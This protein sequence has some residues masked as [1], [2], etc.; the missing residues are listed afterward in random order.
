VIAWDKGLGLDPV[1]VYMFAA[2]IAFFSLVAVEFY[3]R[4]YRGRIEDKRESIWRFVQIETEK[5]RKSIVVPTRSDPKRLS[6]RLNELNKLV[7]RPDDFIKWR[8]WLVVAIVFLGGLSAYVAYMPDQVIFQR[9]NM[10]WFLIAFFL[11]I[12]GNGYFIY[13]VF[14]VDE[15]ITKLEREDERMRMG[16]TATGGAKP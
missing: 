8:K 14:K 12:A 2:A 1:P 3:E 6:S 9:S 16:T 10:E 13:E 7:S 11:V 4:I 5:V 15:Q